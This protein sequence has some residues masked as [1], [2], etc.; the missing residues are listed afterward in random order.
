MTPWG[1]PF[2][3]IAYPIFYILSYRLSIMKR[4][5]ESRSECASHPVE[6]ATAFRK[7]LIELYPQGSETKSRH[8]QILMNGQN[9]CSSMSSGFCVRR[10]LSTRKIDF[11][12]SA[13]VWSAR[14]YEVSHSEGKVFATGSMHGRA[15]R[16]SGPS[17]NK[18]KTD[19]SLS[20]VDLGS[21]QSNFGPTTE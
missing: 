14:S 8:S 1:W 12:N 19:Q 7:A 17:R 9:E 18:R 2:S 5:G 6:T 16:W 21:S 3:H 4:F 20:K 13:T 15:M 11:K 10:S